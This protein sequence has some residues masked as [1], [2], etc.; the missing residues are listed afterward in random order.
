MSKE[1]ESIKVVCDGQ[2][3]LSDNVLYGFGK[4]FYTRF[5]EIV[6]TIL[7]K[8]NLPLESIPEDFMKTLVED[9]FYSKLFFEDVEIFNLSDLS[10]QQAVDLASLLMRLEVDFQKYTKNMP[11]VGGVIKLAVI[12]EKDGFRFILGDKIEQPKHIHL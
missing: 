11:T 1:Q 3:K 8:L 5:P 10:L 12:D 6:K 4:T 2:N 9:P 7:E